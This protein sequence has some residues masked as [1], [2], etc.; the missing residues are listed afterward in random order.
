MKLRKEETFKMCFV[1][2]KV[3]IISYDMNNLIHINIMIVNVSNIFFTIRLICDC[4]IL[5][6]LK[7]IL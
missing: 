2:N 7:N 1:F 4:L 3:Q 6:K 5:N